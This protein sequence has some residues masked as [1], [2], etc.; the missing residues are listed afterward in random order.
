MSTHYAKYEKS[1][2]LQRML[3]LLLDGKK[4][5]T[6]DIILKADI[7]AVN[8]AA[9]ELRVNGFNIRCDQ[10]RP[11]SYWL[12]D[13]AAARQLSSSLLAGKAA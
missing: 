2:R 8:S 13:P 1:L 12:P 11:A 10:K 6:L 7:C 3:E 4:H 9:A 5:T